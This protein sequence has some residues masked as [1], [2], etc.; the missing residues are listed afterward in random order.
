MSSHVAPLN[1][2]TALVMEF[3]DLLIL[4]VRTAS[5][6]VLVRMVSVVMLATELALSARTTAL[7]MVSASDQLA[8]A[9]RASQE[10]TAQQSCPFQSA[11]TAALAMVVALRPPSELSNAIVRLDMRDSTALS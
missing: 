8:N 10:P 11:P 3:V 7:D 4:S 6:C 9:T 2:T 1:S 5:G